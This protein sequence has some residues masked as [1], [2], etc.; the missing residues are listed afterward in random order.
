MRARQR[1]VFLAHET[2]VAHFQYMAQ[3]PA[4]EFARQQIQE[5]GEIVALEAPVWRELP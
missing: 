5:R 3:R 4:I 1:E 2:F